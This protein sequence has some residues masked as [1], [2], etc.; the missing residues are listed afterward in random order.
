MLDILKDLIK[1]STGSPA[2]KDMDVRRREFFRETL[3]QTADVLGEV[4]KEMSAGLPEK[5]YLRPPGAVA[6]Q[7][8]LSL[9]T[10][11][12]E[13]IKVCPHYAI[14]G[15]DDMET[16]LPLGS[17]IIEPRK[18]PCMLCEDLP[19][20]KAC[21]EGALVMPARREDVRMGVAVVNRE[22]CISGNVQF[23]QSC[24]IACPFPDEAITMKDGKPVINK[25]KCTG[26]GI[27][28][29]ACMTVNSACSIKIIPV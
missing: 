5:G 13:C 14:R 9:C 17:P 26:C 27:C 22:T 12:D 20:I 6:E 11:C 3:A 7:E 29:R 4:V 8:F 28:E 10:I 15:A 16:G 1:Y 24:V 18:Q 21:K 23:C 25:E 2:G 19:C